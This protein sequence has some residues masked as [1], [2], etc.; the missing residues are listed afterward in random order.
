VRYIAQQNRLKLR[1]I[2]MDGEGLRPDALEA[3][4]RTTRPRALLHAAHAESAV[5][6]H[7][8]ERRRQI[9]VIAEKYRLTVVETTPTDSCRRNGRRCAA[10]SGTDD[11]R[12][13]SLEES[14][15]GMRLGCVVAPAA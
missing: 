10:D 5:G 11:L 6:G 3:A 4:C 1:G 2:A 9:A 14:V 13:E 15:P 7:V 12:H 8:G